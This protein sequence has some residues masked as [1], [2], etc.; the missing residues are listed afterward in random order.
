MANPSSEK[1]SSI[2]SESILIPEGDSN[3]GLYVKPSYGHNED[4]TGYV[5][6]ALDNNGNVFWDKVEATIIIGDE[7]LEDLANFGVVVSLTTIETSDTIPVVDTK[8]NLK[9]TNVKILSNGDLNTPNK[10]Q[11]TDTTQSTSSSTGCVTLSGGLG[12]LGAIITDDIVHASEFMTLSDKNFKT[13]IKALPLS[14]YTD[15]VNQIRPVSYKIKKDEKDKKDERIKYGIIAQEIPKEIKDIV[16]TVGIGNG[17]KTRLSVDYQSLIPI[18]INTIQSL[19]KRIS[20][21][22][23]GNLK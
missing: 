23:N 9:E 10:I 7:T 15:V 13:D 3:I 18:L 16:T 5:L 12:V 2:N 22:E 8:N 4:I 19:H 20:K 14:D 11:V 6:T 21:L 17:D 1:F